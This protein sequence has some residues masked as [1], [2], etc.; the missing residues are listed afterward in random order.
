MD[1]L[2]SHNALCK[3]ATTKWSWKQLKVLGFLLGGGIRGFG[4]C[5]LICRFCL[6]LFISKYFRNKNNKANPS[7][8]FP[9]TPRPCQQQLSLQDRRCAPTLGA[10][11]CTWKEPG[12]FYNSNFH[13]CGRR[14]RTQTGMAFPDRS[15]QCSRLLC[16]CH[17]S[18]PASISLC[19]SVTSDI[20][21]LPYPKIFTKTKSISISSPSRQN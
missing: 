1:L 8:S 20:V 18:T 11:G 6:D 10:A 21:Q 7:F 3:T 17:C 12:S 2:P 14:S 13:F 9:P 5:S 16:P 19:L 15:R 4:V